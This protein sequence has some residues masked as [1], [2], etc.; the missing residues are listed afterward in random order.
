MLMA[1]GDTNTEIASKLYLAAPT[2]K[3]HFGHIM[4]KLGAN[5]RIQAILMAAL[6]PDGPLGRRGH[7][8]GDLRAR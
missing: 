6:E 5:S 7:G 8:H 1:Q 4:A 2:V 3:S